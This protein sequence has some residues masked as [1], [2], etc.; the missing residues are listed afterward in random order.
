MPDSLDAL[1]R[2][3]LRKLSML[4]EGRTSDYTRPNLHRSAPQSTEPPGAFAGDLSPLTPLVEYHRQQFDRCRGSG[5]SVRLTAIARAEHDYHT[6]KKRPP[7]YLSPDSEENAEERDRAIL[8]V[9]EGYRPEWPAVF[10]DC[11]EAFVRKLR[12]RHKRD[13]MTGEPLFDSIPSV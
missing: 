9:W 13:P 7:A 12:K 5:V 10:E 8:D 2:D 4:A 11:S 1:E 6:V 3:I